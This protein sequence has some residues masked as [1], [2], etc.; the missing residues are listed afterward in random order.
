MSQRQARC[1]SAHAKPRRQPY[2]V[3]VWSLVVI[4]GLRPC[5]VTYLNLLSLVKLLN[6]LS[7]VDP[8]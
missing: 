4:R 7:S 8:L 6:L 1:Q 5:V 3:L 2:A